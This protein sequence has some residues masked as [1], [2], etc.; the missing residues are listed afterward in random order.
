MATLNVNG[1]YSFY[2]DVHTRS[3]LPPYSARFPVLGKCIE[4]SDIEIINFQEV[5]TH[6]QRRL[7]SASLPTFQHCAYESSLTGPRGA[8][9]TFSRLPIQMIRYES[10]SSVSRTADRASLPPLVL[11]KSS[12]KGVLV[13]RLSGVSLAIVNSHPLANYDWDWSSSNRF[14]AIE[15]AQLGK[16]ASIA[17]DL[18]AKGFGVALG[19]DLN[20]AKGSVLFRALLDKAGLRDVFEGDDEPTFHNE[21]VTE[22]RHPECIDYLLVGGRIKAGKRARLFEHKMKIDGG[23]KIFLT[24]HQGLCAE[25]VV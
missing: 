18:E 8:L 13:S 17:R 23:G 15:E 14:R 7:L 6:R 1:L 9:V 10:F 21:F 24:D 20:V 2:K 5:F 3:L 11:A 19:A 25:L 12:L 4:A 16:V 22:G